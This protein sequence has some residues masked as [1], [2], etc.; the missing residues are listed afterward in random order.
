MPISTRRKI[1]NIIDESSDED[2]I[3][4]E[5]SECPEE[6]EETE[7]ETIEETEDETIE[8]EK[9]T[10]DEEET[11]YETEDE[12]LD[13]INRRTGEIREYKQVINSIIKPI[14]NKDSE[15]FNSTQFVKYLKRVGELDPEIEN[16][17]NSPLVK[18][19]Y[20]IQLCELYLILIST[21]HFSLE[22]IDLRNLIKDTIKNINR[23]TC[24]F[25]NIDKKELTKKLLEFKEAKKTTNIPLKEQIVLL[26]APVETKGVLYNK[27][28]ELSDGYSRESEEYSKNYTWLQNALQIPYNNI[29]KLNTGNVCEF[30]TN[31][32]EKLNQEFYGMQKVKEQILL[33]LNMKLTNPDAKGY[34]LA[35]LGDKGVGKCFAMDTKVLIYDGSAKKVQDVKIYDRLIGPQNTLVTVEQIIHGMDVMYTVEQ[36]WS[37]SYKVCKGHLLTLRCV[38]D[39]KYWYTLF[40]NV[41]LYKKGQVVNIPVD[42]FYS[43]SKRLQNKFM[44]IQTP[45]SFNNGIDMEIPP[46]LLGMWYGNSNPNTV[47]FITIKNDSIFNIFKLYAKKFHTF[48]NVLYKSDTMEI[49]LDSRHEKSF[50]NTLKYMGLWGEYK[51]PSSFKNMSYQQKLQFIAGYIDINGIVE[52][53][54]NIITC[55]IMGQKSES[56]ISDLMFLIRSTGLYCKENGNNSIKI[57]GKSELL[58]QIPSLIYTDKYNQTLYREQHISI[59]KETV[60]EYYGFEVKGD[61]QHLFLLEDCTV[62]HNCF[63]PDT[64]IRMFNG[65]TIPVQYIQ[66]GDLLMGDD[67]EYREVV[68]VTQGYEIMYDIIQ[69]YGVKYT[70]NEPHIL[71]LCLEKYHKLSDSI[72]REFDYNLE[73]KEIKFIDKSVDE[74]INEI[75]QHKYYIDLTV[76]E[77]LGHHDTVKQYLKGYK[78]KFDNENIYEQ[79]YDIQ[80]VK[81]DIGRYYGFTLNENSNRRFLLEDGT[82]VHNTHISR[83]LA[84]ILDF[85]FEQISMG[86]VNNPE[87]LTGHQSTYIGSKPG[88]ITS[89]LMKMKCKNG[90]IFLDEFDKIKNVEVSNS[91]LHIVDSTQNSTFTD[92]YFGQEIK[93]DLSNVW[94]VF[95]MNEMPEC[96]PLK[97]RLFII[98][99]DSYKHDEKIQITKNYLLKRICQNIGIDESNIIMDEEMTSYFIHR[100]SKDETNSGVRYIEKALT[101]FINKIA[102]I[103]NTYSTFNNLSFSISEKL[104]YPVTI[105]KKLIDKFIIQE[106]EPINMM[107][108]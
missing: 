11:I 108:I 25:E 57:F 100:I 39:I 21:D 44:A 67:N 2:Y 54:N 99:I 30:L 28:K 103:V 6:F 58:L 59:K 107:Y 61:S 27:Y 69:E 37:A 5:E 24:I 29:R 7:D 49:S 68:N 53:E 84:N 81:K 62:V 47:D 22:W 3:P 42:I 60:E 93:I 63:A 33:Y 105:N 106:K 31:V 40:Y 56:Y 13:E 26:D 76:L 34:N 32:Y 87:I 41:E 64:I 88:V 92:N 4:S 102:F 89:S 45:V 74:F 96:G 43:Y 80:V 85:P 23:K 90:I 94:F 55:I 48:M 82:V 52:Y 15:I 16:I 19:K 72:I 97:D 77:Y 51:I 12:E 66:P 83:T 91:L 71:S 10:T 17:I 95:A 8:T 98:K 104:E 79:L 65:Q 18:E 14:L 70:V 35:L 73:T 20:K 75:N 1:V 78:R 38:K 36:P 50:K 101:D 9:E 86:N 46:Y